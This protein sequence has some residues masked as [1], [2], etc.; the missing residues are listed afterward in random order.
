MT[1]L[2][3]LNTLSSNQFGICK[4][5]PTTDAV[6]N[7]FETIID[8]LENQGHTLDLSKAFDCVDHHRLLC[9][10]DTCGVRNLPIIYLSDR[11][12]CVQIAGLY[13]QNFP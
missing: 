10:L 5:F 9:K 12:Q 1:F 4:G 3:K 11:D 2:N 6:T 13:H 8:G 7:I